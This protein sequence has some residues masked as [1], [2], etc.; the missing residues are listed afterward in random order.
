MRSC[1]VTISTTASM[2]IGRWLMKFRE[3]AHR[4]AF[5]WLNAVRSRSRRTGKSSTRTVIAIPWRHREADGPDCDEPRQLT[6]TEVTSDGWEPD[7][8]TAHVRF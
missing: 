1:G 2:T 7:A 3:E 6:W 8:L 5:R 4:L